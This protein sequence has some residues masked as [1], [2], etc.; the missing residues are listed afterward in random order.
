MM[1]RRALLEGV[2]AGA[3]FNAAPA[4]AQTCG[5]GRFIG[6]LDLRALDDG[7]RMQLLSAYRYV[8]GCGVA[9]HVPMGAIVDGAS[10]PQAFWHI[11][12]GPWEGQFRNASVVHDW[13]CV[14]R[15]RPWRR[16]HR[17]F[18]EAMLTAGVGRPKAAIMYAAV[19]VGGPR[20]SLLNQ[21][22]AA[23]AGLLSSRL[24]AYAT[25]AAGESP[26]EETAADNRE[27]EA[28]G[29]SEE[30][31]RDFA[32]RIERQD[33]GPDQIDTVALRQSR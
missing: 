33:L 5:G 32:E 1:T 28:V 21:I 20:W 14:T 31:F 18:Y 25:D 26:A 4:L 8:D 17:L 3:F 12:G 9:W 11:T 10:I 22:N 13:Y 29:M 2:A 27:G 16:V 30:E 15:S 6:S 7:R 19:M 24:D 23:A